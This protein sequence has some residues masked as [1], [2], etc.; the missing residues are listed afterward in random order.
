MVIF[1]ASSFRAV[2]REI[3]WSD[4]RIEAFLVRVSE[5]E[6]GDSFQLSEIEG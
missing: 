1:S 4:T 3:G 5:L 6:E 2:A